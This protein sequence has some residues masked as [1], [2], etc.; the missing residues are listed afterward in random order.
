M[1]FLEQLVELLFAYKHE[2]TNIV[3]DFNWDIFKENNSLDLCNEM[4]SNVFFLLIVNVPTLVTGN[5]ATCINHSLYNK[6]DVT[7]SGA[8]V[9]DVSDDQYPIFCIIDMS[10]QSCAVT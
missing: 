6:F 7:H 1:V 3:G 9:T 10:V 2:T 5:S 8:F 4:Y